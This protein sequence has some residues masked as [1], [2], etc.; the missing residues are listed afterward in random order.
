MSKSKTLFTA[1]ELEKNLGK[2]YFYRQSL[3]RLV[4]NNEVRSYIVNNI[5]YFSREE[6][7]KLVLQ[8]LAKSIARR[9]PW[10]PTNTLWIKYNKQLKK[11][12]IYGFNKNE[13]IEANTNKQTESD[14]INKIESIRKEVKY[15][16]DVPV[17]PHHDNPPPPPHHGLH[18]PKPP[19][20]EEMMELLRRIE[21]RLRRIEEK[22]ER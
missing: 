5:L 17:K 12:I 21:D 2:K 11:I 4:E 14:L 10:I 13:T 18:H 19:H 22:L 1:Q 7:I 8:K 20:H 3:Y 9:H 15:M 6:V 16:P